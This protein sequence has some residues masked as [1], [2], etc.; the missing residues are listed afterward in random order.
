M[1]LFLLVAFALSV[2]D[3]ASEKE[4]DINDLWAAGRIGLSKTVKIQKHWGQE[5]S[6][7]LEPEY[8]LEYLPVR[9]LGELPMLILEV[10]AYPYTATFYGRPYFLEF[11]KSKQPLG[12]LPVLTYFNEN[13]SPADRIF[14]S[15]AI[16]RYLADK[17]MLNGNGSPEVEA[18]IDALYETVKE[19]PLDA[20]ALKGGRGTNRWLHYKETSNRGD[21]TDY[22]KSAS[23]LITFNNFLKETGTGYLVED[24]LTY[25]DLA[26]FLKLSELSEEDRFPGWHQEVPVPELKAFHDKIESIPAVR[27]YMKSKRRMPRGAP[28]EVD[29]VKDLYYIH[30]KWSSPKHHG[31]GSV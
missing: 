26:L 13:G 12:R 9:A 28:K 18:E 2:L 23:T 4:N 7:T 25:A 8:H 17:A 15:A 20:A 27:R 19:L 6:E 16:V 11:E 30:G 10:S 24:Y 1:K 22:E 3:V 31:G 21:F 14:Q 29:G 5:E